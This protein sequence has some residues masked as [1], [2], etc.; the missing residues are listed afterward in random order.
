MKKSLFILI[1]FSLFGCSEYEATDAS[2]G[3]Q[4]E[5]FDQALKKHLN[6]VQT[7]N[8]REYLSTV[9][10][11]KNISMILPGGRYYNQKDQVQAFHKDWFEQSDF[12][13]QYRIIKKDISK[14]MAYA[15]LDVSLTD[16]GNTSTFY[17]GVI[18]RN[19]NGKW[20]LVH[21]QCTLYKNE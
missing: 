13:F 14:E 20:K 18:F 3:I 6:A 5:D 15:V 9:S 12:D 7:E 19:E 4:V 2:N 8:L 1:I 16:D 17:L 11:G 10:N 21:D